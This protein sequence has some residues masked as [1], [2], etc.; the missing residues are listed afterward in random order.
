MPKR[1]QPGLIEEPLH[2]QIKRQVIDMQAVKR[3][4]NADESGQQTPA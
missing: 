4:R 1:S 3:G 2:Q